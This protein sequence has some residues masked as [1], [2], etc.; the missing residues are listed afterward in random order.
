MEE[1][2]PD[3]TLL[4]E[5]KEPSTYSVLAYPSAKLPETYVAL[6]FARWLRSFRAGNP[7]LK[8][9]S[10]AEYYKHYHK[11]IEMLLSKPDSTVR[12]AVLSDDHDV[13][14]GFSVAREDVLDYVHVQKDHRRQ[15]IAKMLIPQGITTMSHSTHLSVG[16]WQNNP[17]YKHLKLN[18]FA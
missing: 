9:A 6:V 14:L 8:K 4:H 11:H 15:G 10:P 12:L 2:A 7:F 17:K 3:Y 13:V 16:I 5:V 18:P 1:K